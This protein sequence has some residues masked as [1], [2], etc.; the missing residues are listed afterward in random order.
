[1]GIHFKGNKRYLYEFS[2]MMLVHC[3]RCNKCARVVPHDKI[4][5]GD[6]F[7]TDFNKRLATP[8]RLTCE[9]CGYAKEWDGKTVTIDGAKDWFFGQPLWLQTNCSGEL[10]WAL[11][12]RHLQFMEEFVRA[13]IRETHWS[14]SLASS[15]PEWMKLGKNR[16][17][18]LKCLAKLREMLVA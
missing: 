8:R 16:E 12:Q 5:K 10:L 2:D 14:K 4:I 6:S 11:N 9:Y 7:Q 15:L 3:P 13:D 1:M 18:V 17:D